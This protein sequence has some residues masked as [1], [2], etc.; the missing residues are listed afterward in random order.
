MKP[1]FTLIC[2][3]FY[4]YTFSQ[5]L[6]E[7]A[8]NTTTYKFPEFKYKKAPNIEE[9]INY[10]LQIKYLLH[11][12]G[13]FEENPFEKVLDKKNSSNKYKNWKERKLNKNILCV[14]LNHIRNGEPITF[15]EHFDLRTGDFFELF[16]LF[17]NEGKQKLHKIISKKI[18]TLLNKGKLPSKGNTELSYKLLENE[19]AIVFLKAKD[20][21]LIL[22][23]S[24]IKPLLSNY[25]INLLFPS[26]ETLRR[27]D[28]ANKLLKGEGFVDKGG[29]YERKLNY[30]ILISKDAKDGKATIYRWKDTLKNAEKYTDVSIKENII[31]ADD[32]AWDKFAKKRVHLMY[33]L[34]LEKIDKYS[35]EGK[36]QLGSPVYRLIFK[37][38]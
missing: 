9:K 22:N 4:S 35:W 31:Q 13:K 36:F 15:L 5:E 21:D 17:N 29:K 10:F 2:L 14:E 18:E 11:L 20:D 32:Y 37:E 26:K 38:F 16:D 33:S 34:H 30:S 6:V 27:P 25:A 8:S 7:I 28:M 3:C 23:Y 1:F 24:E 19:L 12:P